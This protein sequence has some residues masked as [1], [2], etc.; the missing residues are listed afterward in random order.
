MKKISITIFAAL[1][2]C[3]CQAQNGGNYLGLFGGTSKPLGSF[4]G[5]FR[6]GQHYGIQYTKMLPSSGS[7]SLGLGHL[8]FDPVGQF[9]E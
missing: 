4:D 5:L 1:A 8:R 3:C 2:L 6:P 7:W 9:T